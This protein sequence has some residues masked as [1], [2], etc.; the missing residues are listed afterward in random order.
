MA[1]IENN[2]PQKHTQEQLAYLAGIIDGEGCF[3]TGRIKQGRYGSG[4][5]YHTV[6]KIDNTSEELIEWLKATFGGGR[7]YVWHKLKNPNWKPIYVWYASGKM[8]EYICKSIYPYLIIKK[9]QCELM[10]QFRAT[11]KNRGSKVVEPEVLELRQS[12]IDQMHA[13]NSR[14]PSHNQSTPNK[15]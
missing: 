14:G 13:L 9:K 11:V 2:F 10:L 1:K 15:K 5:Q 3:Y 6:I 4:Y 7:E 8:L 12:I